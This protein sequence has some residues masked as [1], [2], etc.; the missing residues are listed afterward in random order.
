MLE[1]F[2][3]TMPKLE[4]VKVIQGNCHNESPS[5]LI[6]APFDSI[7]PMVRRWPRLLSGLQQSL[8]MAR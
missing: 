1:C 8:D 2:C 7:S 5:S 6:L 4:R 3:F